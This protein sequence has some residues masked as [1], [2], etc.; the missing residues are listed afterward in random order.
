[1]RATRRRRPR[2][3]GLPSRLR[4]KRLI[5]AAASIPSPMPPTRDRRPTLRTTAL[6][7]CKATART[8]RAASGSDFTTAFSVQAART[9]IA[10]RKTYRTRATHSGALSVDRLSHSFRLT[11]LNRRRRSCGNPDT[12]SMLTRITTASQ[13]RL[14]AGLT[15]C[16]LHCCPP[17]ACAWARADRI[18]VD[19]ALRVAVAH[20]EAHVLHRQQ[21][22]RDDV[23]R[24][25]LADSEER[26]LCSLWRLGGMDPSLRLE[27]QR[28]SGHRRQLRSHR[29]AI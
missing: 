11:R 8:S 1:M 23:V 29:G 18:D 10:A 5:T 25:G 9:R 21:L 24:G 12:L 3:D 2:Q 6:A 22:L 26:L 17:A 13:I 16:A 27:P 15:R 28:G 4:V 7:R 19:F 14:S 20:L